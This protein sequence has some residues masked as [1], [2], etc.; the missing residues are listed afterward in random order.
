MDEICTELKSDR[1]CSEGAVSDEGAATVP[2][3]PPVKPRTRTVK[4]GFLLMQKQ[5]SRPKSLRSPD[6]DA[7]VLVQRKNASETVDAQAKLF[8]P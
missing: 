3:G 2:I 6:L 5:V 8:Q 7:V 1:S 4:G